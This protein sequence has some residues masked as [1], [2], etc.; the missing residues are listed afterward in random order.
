MKALKFSLSGK[1]AF[2]KKTDVNQNCYFTYSHIHKV[3]LLGLLG[4]VIGLNGYSKQYEDKTPYPEFYEKLQNLKI[5]IVPIS[6]NPGY[7]NKKII[8]FNNS[9]GLASTE[10]GGALNVKEQWLLNVKWDIYILDD[11]SDVFNKIQNYLTNKKSCYTPYLGKNDHYADIDKVD[12]VDLD[13]CENIDYIHSLYISGDDIIVNTNMLPYDFEPV[14]RY[15]EYLPYKL[16][17]S[18]TY[19][20]ELF[21][22]TNLGIQIINKKYDIYSHENKNLM[23]I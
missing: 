15:F 16:N 10:E 8:E 20:F 11:N 2:F 6:E 18:N 14:T 12:T 13:L 3:S 23:F 21:T 22:F 1:T 4:A 5:A 17:G 19:Q 9:T 7:F